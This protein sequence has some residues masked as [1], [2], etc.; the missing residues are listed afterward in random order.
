MGEMIRWTIMKLLLVIKFHV[1]Q[2]V[3]HIH[4]SNC[5]AQYTCLHL[6]ASPPTILYSTH[7]SMIAYS[8]NNEPIDQYNVVEIGRKL[9]LQCSICIY[10]INQWVL[11]L[12]VIELI[13]AAQV[14]SAL[15]IVQVVLLMAYI[16]ECPPCIRHVTWHVTCEVMQ[17]SC[18]PMTKRLAAAA[19]WCVFCL[20]AMQDR[21]IVDLMTRL[22]RRRQRL[23]PTGIGFRC[24]NNAF[25][26]NLQRERHARLGSLWFIWLLT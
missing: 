4:K 8:M 25:D 6:A 5:P 20:A 1:V 26:G 23:M 24:M 10:G 14:L 3:Q 7:S 17:R 11:L 12:T 18:A 2:V 19:G 22:G 9:L 16:R 13:K 21:C 15:I